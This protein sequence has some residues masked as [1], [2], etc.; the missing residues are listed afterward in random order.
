MLNLL[1]ELFVCSRFVIVL[2][3]FLSNSSFISLI[4]NKIKIFL[5]QLP[6]FLFAQFYLLLPQ[7]PA[8]HRNVTYFGTLPAI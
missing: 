6:S 1:I 5:Y 2:K 8:L 7:S 3:L 4:V